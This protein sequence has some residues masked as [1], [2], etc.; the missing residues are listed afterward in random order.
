MMCTRTTDIY[1][2]LA[3]SFGGYKIDNID[4]VKSIHNDQLE[5]YLYSVQLSILQ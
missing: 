5:L 4:L 2:I 3:A 1:I